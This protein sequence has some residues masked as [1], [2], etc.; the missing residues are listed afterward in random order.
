MLLV[1]W[2][3][4]RRIPCP[5]VLSDLAKANIKEESGLNILLIHQNFPGQFK[6]LG[7]A[8]AARGDRVVA[9]TPRDLKT[10][11]WHGVEIHPYS[12]KRSSTKG[13]MPMIQSM[14]TK[15]IRGESCHDEAIK[16]R[17]SGFNPD[18]IVAH[19][20][21]GEAV[22]LKDVWPNARMGLYCEFYHLNH[23]T[24]VQF[25]PEY[26]AKIPAKKNM[27][28]RIN[29]L[30]NELQFKISDAGLCPTEFQASTFPN[31][32][33]DKLTVLHDGIDTDHLSPDPEAVFKVNET[34]SLDADDE[35]VSF[36]NR[37]LEHYRGYHIFMRALPKL[38]KERPKSQV[39]I[40]G[41]DGTSYGTHAPKGQTWKQIYINEV[42]DQISDEDWTR[43]HFMGRVPY[44]QFRALMAITKAHVYLTYPFVLSW[45]TL[46][47]MSMGAPIVASATAPVE[48]VITDDKTGLLF[49]FF[50]QD[51]LIAQVTRV[52]KSKRLR[53][54]LGKAARKKII[55]EYDLKTIC[56][57]KQ[58]EWIDSLAQ[59]ESSPVDPHLKGMVW[60]NT[61]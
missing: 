13:I 26:Q 32:M 60:E 41:A 18:V 20:G 50:D 22:F 28:L 25:D 56:L 30:V 8:L 35:V 6:H 29:N 43:V 9:L 47:A 58:L 45:S 21:W 59:L 53:T 44:S 2:G 51:A 37:N 36:I 1:Q 27:Q 52:L 23:P 14:E 17:D 34:L 42:R 33:K 55:E 31:H 49:D 5:A 3:L 54:K 4:L 15:L 16:L 7:P 12:Y 57:P 24:L 11:N 48:E 10:Q 46:E 38:L 40:V 39:V 19:H 61:A